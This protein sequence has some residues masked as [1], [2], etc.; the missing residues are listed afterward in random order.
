MS[1]DDGSVLAVLDWE[2]CTLGD[3]LADLGSCSCTGP[4]PT[5]SSPPSSGRR[6]G[7]RVSPAGRKSPPGTP[8]RSG[9][10]LS[11]LDYYVA[12]GYWKVACILEGVYV[13]YAS[14]AYGA[15]D[16]SWRSFETTIPRM[17][18]AA[19][20]AARRSGR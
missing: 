9:R 17:A 11:E 5:T 16:D 6:P 1:P 2:L 7:P 15:T 19:D 8:P 12:L 4:N 3:P 10:D 14:G 20:E 13:R 18:E